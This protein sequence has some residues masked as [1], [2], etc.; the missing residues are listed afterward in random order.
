MTEMT[1]KR[2]FY[3]IVC[4]SMTE[5]PDQKIITFFYI[6][7][8]HWVFLFWKFIFPAY[9]SHVIAILLFLK[10]LQSKMSFFQWPND[11]FEN[12]WWLGICRISWHAF[13]FFYDHFWTTGSC[14]MTYLL[15]PWTLF[16][17]VQQVHVYNQNHNMFITL[18]LLVRFVHLMA[19]NVTNCNANVTSFKILDRMTNTTLK[20]LFSENFGTIWLKCC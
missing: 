12:D 8:T 3:S 6:C 4:S 15:N 20:W 16:R 14:F 10:I 11:F 5:W 1:L 13:C 2:P 19:Q 17:Q 7:W 18:W 9:G